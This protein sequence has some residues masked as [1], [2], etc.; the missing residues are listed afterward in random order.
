[1]SRKRNGT[2]EMGF[3]RSLLGLLTFKSVVKDFAEWVNEEPSYEE[4]IKLMNDKDIDIDKAVS[5]APD[6]K[7]QK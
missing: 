5:F 2:K 7:S 4:T 3:F 6:V 1:M